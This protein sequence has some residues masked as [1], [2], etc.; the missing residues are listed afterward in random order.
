MRTYGSFPSPRRT[1]YADC[2]YFSLHRKPFVK[3]FSD[4]VLRRYLTKVE[5][6]GGPV[7]INYNDSLSVTFDFKIYTYRITLVI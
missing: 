1:H 6:K 7:Y 2:L 3:G 4:S 5:V